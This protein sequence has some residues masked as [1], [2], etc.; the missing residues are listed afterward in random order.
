MIRYDN[1]IHR[2]NIGREY[3]HQTGGLRDTSF[4]MRSWGNVLVESQPRWGKSVR[5]K[6]LVVKISKIRKIIIF[7]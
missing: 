3:D 6:D 1:Q 4:I 5:V 7:D 2:F